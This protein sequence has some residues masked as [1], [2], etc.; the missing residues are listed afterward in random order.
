[1]NTSGT[2]NESEVIV[3]FKGWAMLR[4]PV[5]ITLD[6]IAKGYA[7]DRAIAA[8]KHSKVTAGWVNAGGD[9][10]IFGDIALP[11]HRRELDGRFTP[12]GQLRNAALASSRSSNEVDE[13]YPAAM[14]STQNCAPAEGVW[15]V[16]ANSA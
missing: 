9:M 5:R 1:M 3:P 14:I 16:I 10:R 15:S 4:S 6:G 2:G 12:L 11:V 8:L 7:V 13:R